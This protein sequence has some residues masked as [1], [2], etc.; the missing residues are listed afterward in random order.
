[1][2]G[3]LQRI[4][5]IDVFGG[6]NDRWV[7]MFCSSGGSGVELCCAPLLAVFCVRRLTSGSANKTLM[8]CYL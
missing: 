7:R 8:Q 2:E 6:G 1:M 3:G 5:E 4:L